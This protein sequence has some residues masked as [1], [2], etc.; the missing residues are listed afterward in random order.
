[1][2]AIDIA[3][4]PLLIAVALFVF[5]LPAFSM[6]DEGSASSARAKGLDGLRGFLALGVFFHHLDFMSVYAATG[7]WA[8]HPSAFF[9]FLGRGTVWMFFMITG[10][11]FWGKLIRGSVKW[12]D[13]YIGRLFRIGPLYV[14]VVM[15]MLLIVFA[16]SDFR[17]LQP[18]HQVALQVGRWLALGAVRGLDINGYTDTRL[19]VA[20]VTW[21]LRYEWLFYASLMFIA[22]FAGGR[23]HRIFSAGGALF[24]LVAGYRLDP[25]I[26]P[27]L[28]S[29]FIGMVAAS[30]DKRPIVT[31]N[32]FTA[33]SI[34]AVALVPCMTG[35]VDPSTP[36]GTFLLGASF[37]LIANGASLFGL[38]DL[39]AA[40]RLGNISYSIYLAH[41]LILTLLFSSRYARSA[42]A[43]HTGV[44]WRLGALAMACVLAASCLT[45]LLIERPGIELG[46]RLASKQKRTLAPAASMVGR[47]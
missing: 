26:V 23:R 37:Y 15:A 10:Y 6:L 43:A 21:T 1:L 42:A 45:Y 47:T 5:R 29:F 32:D 9:N 18:A 22:V 25:R 16:R 8:P 33:S 38:L 19:I 13:L 40:R 39:R 12:T 24:L 7:V 31:R 27:H 4:P 28:T 20:G 17:L 35:W 11:L 30:F 2:S 36:P 34:A 14:A 3:M 41:G 46:R 44:D